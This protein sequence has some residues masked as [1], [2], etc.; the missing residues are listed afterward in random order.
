M[1]VKQ[2]NFVLVRSSEDCGSYKVPVWAADG[3]FSHLRMDS[4]TA[5]SHWAW[6]LL[7]NKI[8]MQISMYK[9]F[10]L[11][12]LPLWCLCMKIYCESPP[13]LCCFFPF[14]LG[15]FLTAPLQSLIIV[16][17]AAEPWQVICR[18]VAAVL[19]LASKSF[20]PRIRCHSYKLGWYLF[21]GRVWSN[22]RIHHLEGKKP[23]GFYL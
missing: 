7:F 3:L 10:L 11:G 13:S 9:R 1:S 16:L 5:G 21:F 18:R 2:N 20:F 19:V 23:Q 8:L 6:S 14:C 12:V 22:F 17:L 15:I 4:L